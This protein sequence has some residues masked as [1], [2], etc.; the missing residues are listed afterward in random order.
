MVRMNASTKR[1]KDAASKKGKRTKKKAA[2]KKTAKKKTAGRPTAK[3]SSKR[4]KTTRSSDSRKTSK[5]T[6][7]KKTGAAK[8]RSRK[9]A[10]KKKTKRRTK[11]KP[12]RLPIE[13]PLGPE[14]LLHLED[15][16]HE[17][18][19]GKDDA[20][21]RI[22]QALRVRLTQLDFRPERPNG[23]FLLV[24]PAG[25]GKNE[26]A[27]AIANILFADERFVIP[28]DMRTLTSEEEVSRLTDTIIT[29][30]QPILLEGML[31]T[32][33]RRRPFSIVLLKGIEHAHPASHR[34]VQQII[35]QGWIEDA[36]GR[37]SFENTI[38]IATSRV[39]D[40]EA[41]PSSQIG[42]NQVPKTYEER[43]HAKLSGQFGAEFVEA[44][45]EVI[46]IPTLSPE[47]V[48]RIARYKVK[49]VLDRLKK[50]QRGVE[51][52]ESVYQTFISDEDASRAGAGML[53]RTLESKLLNPLARYLLKHPKD[54]KIRVDVRNGDLVIETTGSAKGIADSHE[55][56]R[57]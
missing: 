34:L 6:A 55:R 4:K 27:Y 30:P 51:V 13:T 19:L 12:Q 36:R 24:G 15:L 22:A 37:V 17:R 57:A 46:V 52:S 23:A 42:F 25:V 1:Q 48:R 39:P 47:D 35:G 2:K 43:V 28:I 20:V 5:K 41:V 53:N 16:M 26:F 31:T 8:G 33:V 11:R 50:R 7:A 54:R 3:K 45:E 40:D 32:P 44:F 18:I 56:P 21:S 38:I 49:V 29:G 10:D 14:I 9:S